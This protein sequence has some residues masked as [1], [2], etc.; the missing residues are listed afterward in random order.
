MELGYFGR[1]LLGC[2]P[3]PGPAAVAAGILLV[4][5]ALI[6]SGGTV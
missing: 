3:L 5:H 6:H 1:R 2:W 4:A